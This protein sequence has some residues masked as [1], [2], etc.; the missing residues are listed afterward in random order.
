MEMP[1]I[2]DF[3][4]ATG[5]S[6]MKVEL[7]VRKR[8]VKRQRFDLPANIEPAGLALLRQIEQQKK[9]RQKARLAALKEL[10]KRA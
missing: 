10:R 9:E 7:K 5:P 6:T 1:P 4:R 8:K 2:P 3:L